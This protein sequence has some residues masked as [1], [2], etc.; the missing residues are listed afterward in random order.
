MIRSVLPWSDEMLEPFEKNDQE[1]GIVKLDREVLSSMMKSWLVPRTT[2]PLQYP[3]EK[4]PAEKD[5]LSSLDQ[6]RS[7]NAKLT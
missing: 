7:N 4:E 2:G 3:I 1:H 6:L 5:S